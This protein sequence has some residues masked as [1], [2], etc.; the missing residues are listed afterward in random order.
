MSTWTKQKLSDFCDVRDGTHDSPKPAMT[1]FP[2]VTSKHIINNKI[3]L[4]SA[5]LIS[6]ED[7]Q[8]VN[9]RSKVDKFDLLISMIGTVGEVALVKENPVFAIKN[10]GLIK[11]NDEALGKY[12]FYF[13][14]SPT[15]KN[16]LESLLTG[17]TQRFISL[18]K[19]RDYPV[20]MPP[21]LYRN[22]ITSVLSA[23]DDLIEN[24][25]KRIKVLEEMAQLLYTEWFVNFNFPMHLCHPELVEGSS[26]NIGY[27]DAG[28]KMVD[29][30]TEYGMIPE[31][32]EVKSLG[33]VVSFLEGPGLR[34]WQYRESGIPFINI[35]TIGNGDIN[36]ANC[37][38][39]DRTEVETKYP[40]FLLNVND[41]VLSSSG[42]LGRLAVVRNRHLPICLN[43]SVIRFR[44]IK[45][46]LPIWFIKQYLLSEVFQNK[47]KGLASGA[48]QLNFGP[49]HLETI[50]LVIP[51]ADILR[52]Y[53]QKISL[54]ESEIGVLRD[55]IQT[56][57]NTRDLLIPQ[58]VTGKRELL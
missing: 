57:S 13:L 55:N 52:I 34:N 4:S 12:L 51:E 54:V 36:I 32:W 30:G 39:L 15:G 16:T 56:L 38:Y 11:T 21:D 10:V 22:K 8:A 58:L 25:E 45:N 3:N 20:T 17:S 53:Y 29:S 47:I 19:L 1:G 18:S 49:S 5:Y 43:T 23:Y 24:N 41:I 42:T 27:K 33:N 14:I 28:G 35:R 50:S 40:H 31:G 6:D 7:Y 46:G 48:A 2:L 26:Q 37:N 9:K 44:E